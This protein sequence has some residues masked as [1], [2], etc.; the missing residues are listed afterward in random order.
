[1]SGW[2]RIADS[3][4]PAHNRVSKNVKLRWR[5]NDLLADLAAISEDKANRSTRKLELALA[6]RLVLLAK[7]F[8]NPLDLA[9]F[10][11]NLVS[12]E[13]YG[14]SKFRLKIERKPDN[15][16]SLKRDRAW[17]REFEQDSIL[18]RVL[19]VRDSHPDWP[20]GRAL[21]KVA[22]NKDLDKPGRFPSFK[23]PDRIRTPDAVRKAYAAS[24]KR[25]KER[26]FVERM[27]VSSPNH[28]ER[29][30]IPKKEK[31]G[32]PPKAEN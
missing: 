22:L 6:R 29:R 14:H 25:A 32:R 10:V 1:M 30:P 18:H 20:L 9:W 26:G 17:L 12:E 23:A 31:R 11:S 19:D 28:V 8:D 15:P 4:I 16:L 5:A 21:A 2:R 3:S 13:P 27:C 7:L 24:L